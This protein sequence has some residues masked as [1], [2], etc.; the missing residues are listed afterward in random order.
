MQ[1]LC[2]IKERKP[3][4]SKANTGGRSAPTTLIVLELSK[5]MRYC[6]MS[7]IL[8]CT[9]TS[10]FTS[11]SRSSPRKFHRHSVVDSIEQDPQLPTAWPEPS[12]RGGT[13]GRRYENPMLCLNPCGSNKDDDD[14]DLRISN[15][16]HRKKEYQS[17]RNEKEV[18]KKAETECMRT[19][20]SQIAHLCRQCI[21][22][23]QLPTPS[24]HT[25]QPLYNLCSALII[26]LRTLR[27]QDLAL[28]IVDHTAAE[29][30][31]DSHRVK[32]VTVLK[33]GKYIAHSCK[34]C[35]DLLCRIGR[36]DV[37]VNADKATQLVPEGILQILSVLFDKFWIRRVG[38]GLYGNHG[39]IQECAANCVVVSNEEIE[40]MIR[41]PIGF[42]KSV[43]SRGVFCKI[44]EAD[45]FHVMRRKS[46]WIVWGQCWWDVV[47]AA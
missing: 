35:G 40:A 32:N 11:D 18:C 38:W 22:P 25:T 44:H 24:A 23:L 21:L 3:W 28:S 6:N 20:T 17:K 47:K 19:S 14:D 43:Q 34:S 33:H 29:M 10:L 26:W 45:L 41:I 16:S 15:I 13:V 39:R 8:A 5:Q 30:T 42:E 7:S 1:P 27:N 9:M 4:K 31:S 36:Y 46:N 12:N 2:P 37:V